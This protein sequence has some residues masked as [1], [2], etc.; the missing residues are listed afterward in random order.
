MTIE[1]DLTRIAVALEGILFHMSGGHRGVDPLSD[2]LTPEV[3]HDATVVAS[4][5][6]AAAATLALSHTLEPDKPTRTRRT[7]AQIEADKQAEAARILAAMQAQVAGAAAP[8][9]APVVAPQVATAGPVQSFTLADFRPRFV[10]L[11]DAGKR[12]DLIALIKSLG[13]AMLTDIKPEQYGALHV[14]LV[15]LEGGHV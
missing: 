7:K 11:A 5:A 13:G 3:S 9:V 8:V 6:A 14:G 15:K 1:N 12:D 4:P 2:A 10:K